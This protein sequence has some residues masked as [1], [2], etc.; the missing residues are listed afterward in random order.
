MVFLVIK[1]NK[2]V[3]SVSKTNWIQISKTMVS[4]QTIIIFLVNRIRQIKTTL[5][6]SLDKIIILLETT[7]IIWTQ[8]V[9]LDK[10]QTQVLTVPKIIHLALIAIILWETKIPIR[11]VKIR[12]VKQIL[13][14]TTILTI[15][16]KLHR[17]ILETTWTNSI[18]LA[19]TIQITNGIIRTNF[20]WVIPTIN[21]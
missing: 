3:C 5:K 20:R 17:I 21:L 15:Y 18:L 1:I 10:N 4:I 6:I 9:Y 8:E 12:I 2:Q 11:L 14:S 13:F 7:I 19:K 16:F